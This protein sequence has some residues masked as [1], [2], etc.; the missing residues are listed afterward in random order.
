[1]GSMDALNWVGYAFIIGWI[2][3]GMGPNLIIG[4]YWTYTTI[5]ENKNKPKKDRQYVMGPLLFTLP[6]VGPI[7]SLIYIGVT[8][9]R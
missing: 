7:L 5:Q 1:M 6:L 8:D 3:C 4:P 2:L 9:G